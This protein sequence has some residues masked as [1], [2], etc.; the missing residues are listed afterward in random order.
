MSLLSRNWFW[1]AI[2]GAILAMHMFGHVGHVGHVGH[3]DHVE[4]YR[5]ARPVTDA[6]AP[7]PPVVAPTGPSATVDDSPT[8]K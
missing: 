6:R 1:I 5:D 4:A 2:I 3:G 7:T 8:K